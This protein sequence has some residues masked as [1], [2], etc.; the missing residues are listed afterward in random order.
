MGVGLYLVDYI[1]KAHGTKLEIESKLDE[2][3]T[4]SFKIDGLLTNT[5][6][7]DIDEENTELENVE[8]VEDLEIEEQQQ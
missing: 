1:L 2:G 3:S 5:H 6:V 8:Q 4:F 7:Q